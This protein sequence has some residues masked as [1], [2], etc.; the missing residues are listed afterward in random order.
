MCR[1]PEALNAENEALHDDLKQMTPKWSMTFLKRL[2]K[3]S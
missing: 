3:M 2:A 1:M